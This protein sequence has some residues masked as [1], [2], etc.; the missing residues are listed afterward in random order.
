MGEEKTLNDVSR[1]DEKQPP[2]VG[3]KKK[4]QKDEKKDEMV[5]FN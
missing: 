4:I 5:V 2:P 3:E 1:K